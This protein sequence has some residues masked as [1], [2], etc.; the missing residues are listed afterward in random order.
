MMKLRL[1]KVK[2]VAKGQQQVHGGAGFSVG[3]LAPS[4]MPFAMGANTFLITVLAALLPQ[5]S[6]PFSP[7]GFGVLQG[8]LKPLHGR[9]P[10]DKSDSLGLDLLCCNPAW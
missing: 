1:S 5:L 4:S 8:S 7:G 6:A 3:H 2:E 9:R 10:G